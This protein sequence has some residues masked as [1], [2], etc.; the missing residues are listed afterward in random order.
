MAAAKSSF[1]ASRT[2]R[3]RSATQERSA[4]DVSGLGCD[5]N[6]GAQL[7][8][9]AVGAVATGT[10]QSR[11]ARAPARQEC[12]RVEIPSCVACSRGIA[13]GSWSGRPE[14]RDGGI[15][16]IGADGPWCCSW[17]RWR[18]WRCWWLGWAAQRWARRVSRR[19]VRF[20]RG[21]ARV[22]LRR[23]RGWSRSCAGK[24]KRIVRGVRASRR[25]RRGCGRVVPTRIYRG[26]SRW[27][28]RVRRTAMCWRRGRRRRFDC[29]VGS[30]CWGMWGLM[31]RGCS[32][33]M[34]A[35]RGWS[36]RCRCARGMRRVT[37]RRS[38]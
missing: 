25:A 26:M 4:C 21:W 17:R 1:T 28:W 30:G 8:A 33:R 11:R 23:R 29:V 31:R 2:P 7:R 22:I 18:V 14:V 16:G 5:D 34:G 15:T 32:L 19:H 10:D 38:I 36:R 9:G 37:W 35:R 24:R 6:R 20:V 13:S 27:R 12:E 3:W